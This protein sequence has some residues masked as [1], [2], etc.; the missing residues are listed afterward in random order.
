M[1]GLG[2]TVCDLGFG[3]KN[4]VNYSK[5]WVQGL[6][7]RVAARARGPRHLQLHLQQRRLLLALH[8]RFCRP[9]T[10]A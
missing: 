2:L 5:L 6:R 3:V 4:W 8:R 9:W 7:T 1:T 10:G